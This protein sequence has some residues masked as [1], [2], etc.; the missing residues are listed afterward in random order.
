MKGFFNNTRPDP[1][2]AILF[3][4]AFMFLSDMGRDSY[5]FHIADTFYLIPTWVPALV[6]GF[7]WLIYKAVGPWIYSNVLIWI[8]YILLV[9]SY[10][11]LFTWK[12]VINGQAI[13]LIFPLLLA[14]LILFLVNIF[15][16]IRKNAKAA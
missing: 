16:G 11:L 7:H 6:M 12:P 8:H 2:M 14:G 5:D 15:M 9:I 4:A 3:L 1:V 13:S 10:L